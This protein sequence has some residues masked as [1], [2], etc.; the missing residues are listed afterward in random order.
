MVLSVKRQWGPG[1][2]ETDRLQWWAWGLEKFKAPGICPR[3]PRDGSHPHASLG[4]LSPSL[5]TQQSWCCSAPIPAAQAAVDMQTTEL[6]S[7]QV[8]DNTQ[9]CPQDARW[10]ETDL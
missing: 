9:Q 7:G 5:E 6:R 1:W 8:R 3:M 2:V 4:P 10:P